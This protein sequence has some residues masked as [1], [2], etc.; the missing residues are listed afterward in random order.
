MFAKVDWTVEKC[1]FETVFVLKFPVAPLE[2]N[3]KNFDVFIFS[4]CWDESITVLFVKIGERMKSYSRRYFLW[5]FPG[6][7]PKMSFESFLKVLCVS[8]CRAESIGILFVEIGSMVEKFFFWG[9]IFY[10]RIP[11]CSPSVKFGTLWLSHIFPL[12]DLNRSVCRF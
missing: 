7:S 2:W 5:K 9:G 4:S 6:C 3:Y 11:S 8:V 10:Y 1:M 12:V